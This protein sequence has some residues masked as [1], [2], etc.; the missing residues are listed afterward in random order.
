MIFL[1]AGSRVFTEYDHMRLELS[2]QFHAFDTKEM[3]IL[4]GGAKGAD[5]LAEQY[6]KENNITFK[7][8]PA[9]WKKYGKVAGFI[10]NKE[11]AEIADRAIVFWDG[12]S[13]GTKHTI[14]QMVEKKKPVV[15]IPF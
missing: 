11:M 15:I 1:I 10:R 12:K 7:L 4:S 14:A 9:N 13:K 3:I 5:T 8:M 6:A 2:F